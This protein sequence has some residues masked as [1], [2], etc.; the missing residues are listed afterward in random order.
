ML[1]RFIT[2]I[3]ALPIVILLVI[4]GD[5]FLLIPVI[6]ASIIGLRE[7]YSAFNV[8]RMRIISYIFS[9]LFLLSLYIPPELLLEFLI[10]TDIILIMA[11]FVVS[12]NFI[13]VF[14]Y[15]KVS[16][17]DIG[18]IL[19]GFFYI[20]FMLAFLILV[21]E[22]EGGFY[23]VWLIFISCFGCDIFAYLTGTLIGRRK[24]VNS[25]SPSKSVEGLIGGVIG[26]TLLGFA[27]GFIIVI[28]D[29]SGEVMIMTTITCFFGAIFSIVGD[30]SA[31]AIKRHTDIKD[32]GKLFPGHGGMLDRLDSI[33]MVAP[34]VYLVM[35]IWWW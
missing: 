29:G 24:L 19:Y 23:F 22:S 33:L 15:K 12:I 27:F 17:R 11:F 10:P 25:P 31:S 26:S 7:F 34:F 13:I 3:I 9:S 4:L 6:I 18:I 35:F 16:L 2:T 5:I 14:L 28:I 21:R 8:K 32:F 20:P 30:L 1:K